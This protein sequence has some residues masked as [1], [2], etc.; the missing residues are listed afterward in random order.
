MVAEINHHVQAA[1]V[2]LA[3]TVYVSGLMMTDY[4][5]SMRVSG[6]HGESLLLS[7]MEPRVVYHTGLLSQISGFFIMYA[8]AVSYFV[9]A[10]YDDTTP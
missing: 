8:V 5:A 9:T 3:L 10:T 7:T 4:G 1:L 2:F 6:G